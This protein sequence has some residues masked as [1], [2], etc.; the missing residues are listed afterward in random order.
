MVSECASILNVDIC[1]EK[2][3]FL[4]N[5]F[6]FLNVHYFLNSFYQ[7]ELTYILMELLRF[8]LGIIKQVLDN[9]VHNA[10]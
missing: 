3:Y 2:L 5:G 6:L 7:I 9:E 10:S 8:D 4:I 1:C